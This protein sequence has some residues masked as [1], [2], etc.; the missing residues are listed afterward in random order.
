MTAMNN[1]QPTYDTAGMNMVGQGTPVQTLTLDGS[2]TSVPVTNNL[3][4]GVMYRLLSRVDFFYVFG[5]SPSADD[6]DIPVGANFPEYITPLTATKIAVC[7]DGDS[8]SVWV[9]K[10]QRYGE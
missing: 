7:D 2:Q 3:E 8:G 4:A 1:G 9:T 6:D 5:D 10:M